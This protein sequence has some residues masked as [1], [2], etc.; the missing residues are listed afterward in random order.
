[1]T[2]QISSFIKTFIAGGTEELLLLQHR[3]LLSLSVCPHL[4]L[5]LLRAEAGEDEQGGGGAGGW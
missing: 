1:M 5:H 4:C 3:N 2:P